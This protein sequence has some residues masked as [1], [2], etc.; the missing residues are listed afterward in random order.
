VH[1]LYR[2]AVGDGMT[3]LTGAEFIARLS[4]LPL[5]HPPGA[6]WHYGWG[7]DLLGLVIESITKRSLG[8]YLREHLFEPLGMHD[9]SFGVPAGAA[10]R[11]AK[12]LP[13]DPLTGLAQSLPDLSRARFHSGGAGVVT[14]AR[15]Y[16]HFALMLQNGGALGDTRIL[17]RKTVEHM[18]TESARPGGGRSRHRRRGLSAR[19][20]RLRSRRCRSA[21]TR[22][23]TRDG[24]IGDATW[25]GAGGT[26][27]WIDPHEQL[28]VTFHAHTPGRAHC[29]YYHRLIR[30]LVLQALVDS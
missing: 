21:N 2:E 19:R 22:D 11:Y 1:A 4:P 26:Y 20:V 17:G 5:L 28:A 27:W 14:T 12:A 30:T 18:L 6:I 13:N 7:L 16:L 29:R 15:D 23:I 10:A 8:D 9:T 3:A 25:P 24:S